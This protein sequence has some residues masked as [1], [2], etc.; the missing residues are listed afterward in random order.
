MGF[1]GN[2][3]TN[4][5]NQTEQNHGCFGRLLCVTSSSPWLRTAGPCQPHSLPEWP[6]HHCLP[7]GWYRAVVMAAAGC[8]SYGDGRPWQEDSRGF[9]FLVAPRS[10]PPEQRD[11]SCP[12]CRSALQTGDGRGCGLPEMPPAAVW[13][14]PAASASRGR[15]A[16]VSPGAP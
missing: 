9:S 8:G 5:P 3:P 15:G 1:S 13:K 4:Q 6:L 11:A 16:R 14:G 2:Q 7:S 10:P 12:H